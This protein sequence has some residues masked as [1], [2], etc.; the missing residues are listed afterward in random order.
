MNLAILIALVLRVSIVLLVFA[1]GLDV[2]VRDTTYL[3]RRKGLLLRSLLAMNVVM[4]LVAAALVA[5][6]DLHPAVKIA[7]VALSVS[8][9]PPLLP[10]KELKAGGGFSFI[11]S[12]LVIQAVLAVFLVP[13]GIGLFGIVF[14]VPARVPPAA[15]ASIVLI[16]V[17]APLAG[18]LL[19][20]R[21]ARPFAE[22]IAAPVSRLATALLVASLL[23][24]LITKMPEIVSLFGNGTIVAI[25]A[26]IVVGLAAGH[27]LGGPE[28]ED[29][30]VLALSASSRHP[31]V[32]L[33]I[34]VASFPEQK[35]VLAA[36][37]LYLM[38]NAVVSLP[39]LAW[40]R[41]RNP[42]KQSRPE[43]AG[44]RALPGIERTLRRSG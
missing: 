36:I 23:P 40:R 25:A 4:P 5:A 29:R 1:L 37:L 15:V 30:T 33:A 6:F 38:L 44:E 34:A 2:T 14:A 9:V 21:L 31:A 18:G 10:I 13:A 43:Q 3:L 42:P 35:L 26:F 7:V 17:I 22:R 20:G 24:I 12:L 27:L 16:T 32:A 39:Y 8:P 19:V 11:F 41:R 28:P